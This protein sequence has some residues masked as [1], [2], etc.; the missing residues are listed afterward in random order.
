MIVHR[1]LYTITSQLNPEQAIKKEIV[2][3]AL[4]WS[5]EIDGRKFWLAKAE[6]LY[7]L[8]VKYRELYENCA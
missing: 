8:T 1:N 3:A 2:E 5:R 4:A 6:Y 7:K